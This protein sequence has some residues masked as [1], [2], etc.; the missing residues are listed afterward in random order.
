MSLRIYVLALVFFAATAA[1]AQVEPVAN[2][3]PDQEIPCAPAS[4]VEVM[5]DGSGS[6]G[7]SLTYSWT[8][9]T[10]T[11]TGVMPTLT[12]LPD[13]EAYTFTLTVT[14][15]AGAISDPDEVIIFV[16]ADEAHSQ[17]RQSG[18]H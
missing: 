10:E 13:D 17:H 18:T 12:L 3:G 16:D 9:G 7:D 11:V 4:G 8:D 15:G 5:L 14:D 1:A 6:T 2:A